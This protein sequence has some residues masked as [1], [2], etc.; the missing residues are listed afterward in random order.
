[1]GGMLTPGPDGHRARGGGRRQCGIS[2]AVMARFGFSYDWRTTP[3]VFSFGLVPQ[4][5]YVEVDDDTFRVRFGPWLRLDA[6]RAAIEAADEATGHSALLR[7]A[8][9]TRTGN[10]ASLALRTAK[11][12]VVRIRFAEQQQARAP[13]GLPRLKPEVALVV[14]TPVYPVNDLTLSVADRG[15]VLEA[16]GFA[17]LD[18]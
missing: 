16:L 8:T 10:H 18:V 14:I 4:L 9:T 17:S 13:L 7:P 2:F 11:G 3:M 12:P 1:M 6:P 15:G 5:T